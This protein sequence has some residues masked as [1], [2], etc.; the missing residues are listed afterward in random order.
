VN[1]NT[2]PRSRLTPASAVTRRAPASCPSALAASADTPKRRP[3]CNPWHRK[4]M[5]LL[6]A[7]SC[8]VRSAA[9]VPTSAGH[10]CSPS[11]PSSPVPPSTPALGSSV[12]ATWVAMHK[13]NLLGMHRAEAPRL[14]CDG[15]RSC[16]A[17]CEVSNILVVYLGLLSLSFSSI[18]CWSMQ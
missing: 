8:M 17:T 6:R 15:T 14:L 3:Q 13:D 7:L 12:H 4:G 11:G 9:H 1:V 16:E 2:E 10:C 18:H 5:H